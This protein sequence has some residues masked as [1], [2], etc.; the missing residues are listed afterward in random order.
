[1][2]EAAVVPLLDYALG[3]V[4]VA[5]VALKEGNQADA[6]SLLEHCR[7]NMAPFK[8]PR[9]IEFTSSLPKNSAGKVLK[10]KLKETMVKGDITRRTPRP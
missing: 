5:I 2:A 6:D 10:A 4:P 7:M 9:A 1:M 3:E 8:V